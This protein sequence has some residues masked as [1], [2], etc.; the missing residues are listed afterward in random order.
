MFNAMVDMLHGLCDV[1][2]WE[3][4]ICQEAVMVMCLGRLICIHIIMMDT[5]YHNIKYRVMYVSE[6]IV[7]LQ[8]FFAQIVYVKA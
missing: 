2:G 5:F 8:F 4:G 6:G 1:Q 3:G 7:H